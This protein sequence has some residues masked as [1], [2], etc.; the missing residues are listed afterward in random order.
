MTNERVTRWASRL[1]SLVVVTTM[2][3]CVGCASNPGLG[4]DLLFGVL[5][6]FYSDGGGTAFDQQDDYRE[7]VAEANETA[8]AAAH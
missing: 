7:R 2:V 5:Q 1:F 8:A 3:A 6:P 4:H